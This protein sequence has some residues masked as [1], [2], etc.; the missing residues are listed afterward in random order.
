MKELVLTRGKVALVDDAD[1]Q[2]FNQYKWQAMKVKH[3]W[4]AMRSI[5]VDKKLRIILLHREIL[6][7]QHKDGIMTDHRN[8][9]GLDDRR[10]NL[11]ACTHTDNMRNRKTQK[12]SSVFKGV[13][14]VKRVGRWIAYI[15]VNNK[16]IHLGYF[17]DES[18]AALAYNDA[19]QKY[20]GEFARLNSLRATA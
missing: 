3:L 14:W 2:R 9:N 11:R 16:T 17:H 5:H 10:C 12:H 1:F 20:F 4:Y 15:S 18:E 8:G 19:A 13:A 6:G 7:L